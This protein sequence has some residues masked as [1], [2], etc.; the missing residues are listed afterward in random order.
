M[1]SDKRS[2]VSRTQ[3]TQR[4]LVHGEGIINTG[5]ERW[6]KGETDTQE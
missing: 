1:E 6:K 5:E 2:T 3:S 4:H